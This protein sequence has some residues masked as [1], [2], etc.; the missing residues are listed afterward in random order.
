MTKARRSSRATSATSH[1][2]S[3]LSS[4]TGNDWPRNSS[5]FKEQQ[6]AA[7]PDGPERARP[8]GP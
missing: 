2:I 5:E 4:L 1:G 3:R 6:R 7:E 8:Q